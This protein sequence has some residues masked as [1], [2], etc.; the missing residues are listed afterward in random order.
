[1]LL[2]QFLEAPV[3]SSKLLVFDP[4]RD[5]DRDASSNATQTADHLGL[6]AGNAAPLAAP[7]HHLPPSLTAQG[8]F[9]STRHT[10]GIL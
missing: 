3:T 2:K 7:H 9:L 4:F 8:A 5:L 10:S 6:F 1:M